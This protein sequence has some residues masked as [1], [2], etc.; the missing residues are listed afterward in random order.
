MA[1]LKL[2][3]ISP[4]EVVSF[5]D[6]GGRKLICGCEFPD[7]KEYPIVCFK[8]Q[9]FPYITGEFEADVETKQNGLYKDRRIVQIYKDGNPVITKSNWKG[10]SPEELIVGRYKNR[11]IEAQTALI[12]AVAFYQGEDHHEVVNIAGDFLAFID[13]AHNPREYT[14]EDRELVNNVMRKHKL[15]PDDV[16][17]ILEVKTMEEWLK[18]HTVNQ[19]VEKI[20]RAMKQ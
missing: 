19:A 17:D 1:R 8:P 3:V 5:G 13:S 4:S 18:N 10:K 11:S 15:T 20:E 2:K 9:L 7:S 12:Q 6:R 14:P 16:R